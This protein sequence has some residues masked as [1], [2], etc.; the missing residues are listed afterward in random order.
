MVLIIPVAVSLT[1]AAGAIAQGLNGSP[2]PDVTWPDAVSPNPAAV[3]GAQSNQKSPPKYPSP[4][5]DGSGGWSAA[6]DK[7][8]ALV[9]KL[10]LEEKVNLT[11]GTGWQ[12]DRC[13]GNTGEI[14][15][16][17]IRSLCFQDAPTAVRYTDFVSVFPQ[18][19]NVAASFDKKLAYLRGQTMGEEFQAKGASCALGPVAGPL[20]R[21][22]EGGRNWEGF[23]PDP[24]LTG[25]MFAESIKGIQSTGMMASAK[26]FIAN[27]QEHF[28]QLGEALD[29]G[30]NITQP[31][32]SNFDDQTLHE[33][34]LWPF[35]DGVR[36]G[37]ANVMC[38]Y[39]LVNNSQACQNSYLLNHVLKGE[40]GFQG[41]VIS[42]WQADNSGVSAILAGLDMSMPGDTLFNTGRSFFGPNL[43]IAVL[44]GTVPQWRLDDM[45]VRIL[46]GWYYVDG[47]TKSIP[48]NF[49]SF[50]KDTY[51]PL[52]YHVGTQWG[53]GL[54]NEHVDSRGEHGALIRQWGAESTVLLK[55][56]GILPLTGKE[57]LT[58]V[59]GEDAAPNPNGPNG[60]SNKGCD[61]GTLAEAWGSGQGDFPYL[62]SPEAALQ[63]EIVSHYGAFESITNNSALTQIQ[64]LSRRTNAVSG[65]C[66]AFAN[67]DSGEGFIN[68]EGNY[69]D[70]KNL[71]FWQAAE[72]MLQNVT[73]NCNR[74]VLVIHSVGPI[75]IQK[76]KDNVN[77]SAIVWAGLPGEQSGNSLA[78]VLYGRV[79]PGAKL[80]FT[81]GASR[82]EYGAD[83]LYTPNQPVP[84]FNFQEGVFVDYRA[85]DHRNI[86]PV[87]EFGFGL[88]YTE[89][90][91]AD[92]QIEKC[93]AA[94]YEPASSVSDAAPIYG[95]I[96]NR[97]TTHLF[98]SN[99]T[100][101][102]LY[103]YPWLN[104]TN[105]SS[106]YGGSGYGDSAFIPD[107]ALDGSPIATHP[108][109]GAPGGNPQLWDVLYR[110]TATVSNV[111][112]L[113]G[114]EVPQLYVS[115][116]GPFD[117][118]RVL[119]GFEKLLIEPGQSTSVTFELSRRDLSN[120]DTV[121]QNWVITDYT[122]TVFVG[123]SSR[124]L[125][126]TAVLQ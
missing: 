85:F 70:R 79:N 104:S 75:E 1:L 56:D 76:Y 117:P 45:A 21:S 63:H 92:L 5:A 24:Y 66:I 61:I 101:V 111:G 78:D 44:N 8:V 29:Y 106:A 113:A 11:T 88:S 43:T 47:D 103:I 46:A 86:T 105:L 94:P 31:G 102:P 62:V 71:T 48:V 118:K 124:A 30:F 25:H 100:R 23:S 39:N 58:A 109:G 4:W 20:G 52:H 123:S 96:D 74:T 19:V 98:P 38:S 10:T 34:Y 7:A 15:R 110:V 28:R 82:E 87:Y 60:C 36:A 69:G 108:A 122:K 41:F 112:S 97:T 50:T 13:V 59:F 26:H 37:V 54:I 53:T 2:F 35:A 91:Y 42:D 125:P 99:F 18:G 49:E 114:A 126:L 90:E 27:E 72:P 81:L 55:N 40:L 64:T 65:V 22:P 120:W 57:R 51:G 116:G 119:R 107:G 84:Q 115:H 80:P 32:S 93:G 73:T 6:Y 3:A 67:A 83:V 33:L 68:I 89:F 9:K 95:T 14:P 77:V 121:S 17:G 16:L 12:M